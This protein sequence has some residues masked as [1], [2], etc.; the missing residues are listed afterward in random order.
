MALL[1]WLYERWDRFGGRASRNTIDEAGASIL[2][3][4]RLNSDDWE[5]KFLR[6]C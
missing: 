1:E 4:L 3:R 2:R 5:T 6:K